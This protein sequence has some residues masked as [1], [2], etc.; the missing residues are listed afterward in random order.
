MAIPYLNNAIGAVDLILATASVDVVAILDGFTQILQ[1]A[2]PLK[3]SCRQSSRICDHPLEDGQPISDYSIILPAEIDYPVIVPAK[4][5][6]STYQQILQLFQTKQV[7]TVQ[8]KTG[9]FVNMVITDI[10]HEE[11]AQMF[12]AFQM[13][14]KLRQILAVQ[15]APPFVPANPVQANTVALGQQTQVT[16][17]VSSTGTGDYSSVPNVGSSG[18]TITGVQT[19]NGVQTITNEATNIPVTGA[20]T[21]TSQ[22]TVNSSFSS[23]GSV[24]AQTTGGL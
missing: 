5:Y 20:Q 23:L 19:Q 6:R 7:L 2:R 13:T 11:T 16:P 17:N 4:Y 3:A 15:G 10:P 18:Y 1:N 14:I 12:D 8:L 9:N 22:S 21:I 24:H